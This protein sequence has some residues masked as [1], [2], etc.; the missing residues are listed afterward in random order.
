[1]S[2]T[3]RTSQRYGGDRHD[4]W[5]R[6]SLSYQRNRRCI[7]RACASCSY[8]RDTLKHIRTGRH[9]SIPHIGDGNFNV[10]ADMNHEISVVTAKPNDPSEIAAQTDHAL[11]QCWIQSRPVYITLPTSVIQKKIEGE[12]LKTPI[13]LA[14][15]TNNADKEIYVVDAMLKYFLATKN[16]I[17]LIDTCAIR[18]LAIKEVHDLIEKTRLPIFLTPMGKGTVNETH[19][20][21]GGF[22]TGDGSQPDVRERVEV[23][24][25]IL[26]IDSI[27]VHQIALL[28]EQT[29]TDSHIERF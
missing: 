29:Q 5:S 11:Q 12:R 2:Q 16:P 18:H 24:D 15:P 4:F 10:F 22:Y 19:L 1:M 13:N 23:S 21:Y 20:A 28:V 6:R 17:I 27:K 14:F 7:F 9:S 8:C 26:T 3:V 25:L